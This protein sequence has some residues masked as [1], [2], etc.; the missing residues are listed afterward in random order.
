MQTSGC[1]L[2]AGSCCAETGLYLSEGGVWFRRLCPYNWPRDTYKG[3]AAHEGMKPGSGLQVSP[4]AR[5]DM[6]TR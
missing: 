2:Q 6:G 3:G 5:E 4:P 1:I